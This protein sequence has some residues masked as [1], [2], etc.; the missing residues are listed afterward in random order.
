MNLLTILFYIFRQENLTQV[1]IWH[2]F[3]TSTVQYSNSI[4]ANSDRNTS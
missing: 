1:K 4:L 2:K 3:E